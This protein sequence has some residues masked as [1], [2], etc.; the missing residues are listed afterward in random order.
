MKRAVVPLFALVCCAFASTACMP[1]RWYRDYQS[2]DQVAARARSKP[3]LRVLFVGNSFTMGIPAALAKA[4]G[5][6]GKRVEIGMVAYDRWTLLRHARSRVTR[7]TIRGGGWD[8]VVL[9]EQ[10]ERPG[11]WWERNF[12]MIPALGSLAAQAHDQ[13]AVPVLYQTWGCRDEF[14]ESNRRVANGCRLAVEKL[15]GIGIVHVGDAWADEVEHGNIGALFMPD[16]KH[17]TRYGNQVTARVFHNA[18]RQVTPAIE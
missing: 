13:G 10:S 15:G 11:K 1:G 2:L 4:A 14:A 16:G 18:F 3:A 7:E 8:V 12:F 5:P 17:P 6:S 9:Q